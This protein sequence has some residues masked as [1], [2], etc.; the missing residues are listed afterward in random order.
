M[1]YRPVIMSQ[2]HGH[3]EPWTSPDGSFSCDLLPLYHPSWVLR[4]GEEELMLA[5]LSAL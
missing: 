1:D 4:T 5:D 3:R 2:R